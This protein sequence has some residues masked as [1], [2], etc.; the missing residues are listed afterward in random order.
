MTGDGGIF[1]FVD[2]LEECKTLCSF[3]EQYRE[4]INN[5][6]KAADQEGCS[7]LYLYS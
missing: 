1:M 4:I 2:Q 6:I 7:N 5:I 3:S